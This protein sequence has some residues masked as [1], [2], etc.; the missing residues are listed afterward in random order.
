MIRGNLEHF[1]LISR[2]TN[3]II[4]FD[5]LEKFFQTQEKEGSHDLK[6]FFFQYIVREQI[7]I[8]NKQDDFYTIFHQEF[9][10]NISK[11]IKKDEI[12]ETIRCL[13]YIFYKVKNYKG[14]TSYKKY[15]QEFKENCE[16]ES[17]L[18]E[19]KFNKYFDW[20]KKNSNIAPSYQL[21]W[22][23]VNVCVIALFL[24]FNPLL[25]KIK[26]YQFIENSPFFIS[27]KTSNNNFAVELSGY[28]I[29][30]RPYL[31]DFIKFIKRLKRSNYIT[32]SF[33]LLRASQ[34]HLIN[35]NYLRE[36]SQKYR[37]I[38]PNHQ[39]YDK[40]N[41]IEFQVDFGKKFSEPS[42]SVLEFSI[43]DRIRML[44]IGGFGFER[45]AETLKTLKSDLIN[46]IITQRAIISKLNS[47]LNNLY[48]LE[49]LKSQFLQFLTKNMNYGFFIIKN[50]LEVYLIVMN[51][52]EDVRVN[53]KQIKSKSNFNDIIKSRYQSHLIENNLLLSDPHL[54]KPI[55]RDVISIFFETKE[56][57]K[58]E[59][60][61][62]KSFYDLIIAFYNMKLFNINMIKKIVINKELVQKIYSIKEEKLEKIY[63][64]FKLSQI[65]SQVIN[66]ILDKL[67]NNRPPIISPL[68]INTVI[69]K[70]YV[71]DFLQL[72]LTNSTETRKIL[73]QIQIFF[74][75]ILINYTKEL[76]SD[77]KLVYVEI[78]TPYFTKK[79]KGLLFSILYNNFKKEM[80]Y[81]KFFLWTGMI[82]G[83][84]SKNFY[85][86]GQKEFFFTKDLYDQY[87]LY[88]KNIFGSYLESWKEE[89]NEN[90]ECF[91]SKEKNLLDLVKKVND[92]VMS[93][94]HDYNE[95]HLNKL[96]DF[97]ENQKNY[98]L[99]KEKFKMLKQEYF[100]TNFIKTIKFIPSLEYFGL[101]QYFLYLYPT[102]MNELDFKL[103]LLNTFQKIKYPTS[104]DSSNS[105]FIKY[106]MPYGS[107][108]LKYLHWLARSKKIIREY[109][110]FFINKVYKILHFNNKLSQQGWIYDKDKFKMHMQ[111]VLFNPK[112]KPVNSINMAFEIGNKSISSYLG[113]ESL[114]FESLSQIYD[115]QSIDIKSYLATKKAKT[116]NHIT[117]LLKKNLIFP[118]LSLKNLDLHNIVY[119]IVPNLKK[120]SID[121]VV[122]VFSF[123]NVA[124]IYETRGEYFI[125]GFKQEI[126][127]PTGLMIKVYFPKCEISEF[128]RL[129]DL[130]FEYL[131]VKNY[132]ILNDL[133]D[134]SSLVKSVYG[135]LDFLKSYN[136]LKNLE[137]NKQQKRWENPKVFTSKFDPIYPD[138]VA[139][140]ER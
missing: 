47:N 54:I 72:I 57:I 68:L 40:R 109:C 59:V 137:W 61:K 118:Y 4:N 12:I 83:F 99:N 20:I 71:N 139:K 129:F 76:I 51:F 85:D 38:N 132:V 135:G 42:L 45:R 107:P 140:D 112:Y 130:L 64:K 89:K 128:E 39:A 138:L 134:G 131:E 91:W 22:N 115:T 8:T 33:C 37:I 97:H 62:Y 103:L 110:G 96:I 124:T 105:L 32:K 50:M 18:S 10:N 117:S 94:N 122:K 41:E 133:V 56:V 25:A 52:A 9:V 90:Q 111:E 36:Y 102:N 88:V 17:E 84:L 1:D 93:E 74:P 108:N 55:I 11:L 123:F 48:L 119:I 75:R 116:I 21:N 30:P 23:E 101:G 44:S 66:N 127:F 43:L 121:T 63:E 80:L 15:F 126:R 86:F 65:T 13:I 79:E 46:E 92:R 16:I 2:G 136:P 58:E 73:K 34:N 100:F 95:T 24:R 113:P 7:F 82:K 35:L 14:L 120:E 106:I 31:D 81:G 78:S 29:L 87:F 26:V 69:M 49:D 3:R 60:K 28:M 5:R 70:E 6:K 77:E 104:I 98:L 27:L 125:Y 53:N 114:E 67:L 19:R